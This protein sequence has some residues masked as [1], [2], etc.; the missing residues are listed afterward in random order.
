[1]SPTRPRVEVAKTTTTTPTSDRVV[2]PINPVP[3][4]R[5]R[6]AKFGT[7]YPKTYANYRK[8][9]HSWCE[10]QEWVPATG[11]LEVTCEFVV[12][13]PRT[14]KLDHPN[15]DIDNYVKAAWDVLNERAWVDDK[16][17][18]T[19][20]LNKRFAEPGEVPHTRIEWKAIV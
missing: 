18:I 20:R 1:M 8:E 17:I 9:A 4:A 7:Y 11:P 14:S 12:A 10:H 15:G 6:V 5:P 3:A 19:A 13:K 2:L 16:Q